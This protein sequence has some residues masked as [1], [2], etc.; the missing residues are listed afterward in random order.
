MSKLNTESQITFK[1]LSVEEIK[2]FNI[3]DYYSKPTEANVLP[4]VISEE[5]GL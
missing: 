4:F 5:K 2:S 3:C 1:K